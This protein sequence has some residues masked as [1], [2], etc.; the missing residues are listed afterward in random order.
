MP[1]TVGLS[2]LVATDEK[3]IIVLASK[4]ET[5]DVDS[6]AVGVMPRVTALL[7]VLAVEVSALLA[8]RVERMGP[9]ESWELRVDRM[10][11]AA[12]LGRACRPGHSNTG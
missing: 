4:D 7:A 9:G 8:G 12:A 10:E 6:A 3:L 11:D 2:T 5:L 1:G